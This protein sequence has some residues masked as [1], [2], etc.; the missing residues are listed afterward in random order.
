[1]KQEIATVIVD[2]PALKSLETIP[3]RH[4]KILIAY[5]CLLHAPSYKLKQKRVE[6]G[7]SESAGITTNGGDVL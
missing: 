5:S 6:N 3:F 4:H 7:A 2:M 1:M